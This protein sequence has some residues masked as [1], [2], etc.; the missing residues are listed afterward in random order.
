MNRDKRTIRGTVVAWQN[1]QQRLAAE[2]QRKLQAEADERA[3]LE[4]ERL[5]K[6]ASTYKTEAKKQEVMAQAEA[7]IAPTVT[8]EA[9]KAIGVRRVWKCVEVDLPKFLAA[10]VSDANLHGYIEV[11]LTRLE[12]AKSANPSL[13]VAGCT[14]EHQVK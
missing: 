3:R 8:V 13:T 11:A 1:E 2:R 14:F 9:P 10:A 5:E 7:V 12:R 6:K 4:R